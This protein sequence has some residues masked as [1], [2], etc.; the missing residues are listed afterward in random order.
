MARTRRFP[1]DLGLARGARASLRHPEIGAGRRVAALGGAVALVLLAV[2]I[3]ACGEGSPAAAG[4]WAIDTLDGGVV[5]T[6]NPGSPAVLEGAPLALQH[7][8]R[9][10][11]ADG[12][13]AEVF[14]Q[15]IGV[16]GDDDGRVYVLDRQANEL[17]IFSPVGEHLHT[18]GRSGGGPGEY[19]NANGLRWAAPDT[20]LVVDQSGG[21]YTF[22]TREGEYVRSARRDLGFFGWNFDGALVGDRIYE[23]GIARTPES[24]SSQPAII[25]VPV[26]GNGGR[27][28]TLP[29]PPTEQPASSTFSVQSDAGSMFMEV[30]FAATRVL[31]LDPEGGLWHGHGSEMRIFRSTLDGDTVREIRADIRPTP[32]APEEREEW[33]AGASVERFREMGG[34]LDPDRIPNTKPHFDGLYRDPDGYLWVSVPVGP[35]DAR[36]VVFD[37]EGRFV[38]DL[39]LEG[40]RRIPRVPPAVRGD[41][42]Y[43]ATLDEL[44]V[45]GVQVFEIV[46]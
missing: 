19:Q 22:L 20:L 18:A 8:L 15:I 9:L 1:F 13:E 12:P 41:R 10:G 16:E 3:S 33:L 42:L 11:A 17:R 4:E 30:P 29:V 14:G 27:G 26:R 28:D 38:S 5:R 45:P 40:V 34:D 43:L 21:R 32:V 24:E 31:H 46:R 37:P 35:A 2:T 6:T 36:F 25:A 44:E 39:P 7:V 23:L